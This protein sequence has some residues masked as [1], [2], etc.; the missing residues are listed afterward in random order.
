MGGPVLEQK[1]PKTKKQNPPPPKKNEG[2]LGAMPRDE[3][4][5]GGTSGGMAEMFNFIWGTTED[6]GS[7]HTSRFAFSQECF[8]NGERTVGLGDR[9]GRARSRGG[10]HDGGLLVVARTA[11]R[12]GAGAVG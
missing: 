3:V 10:L 12:Q 9:A 1:N 7:G 6:R 11:C 2:T 5:L 8:L 4:G